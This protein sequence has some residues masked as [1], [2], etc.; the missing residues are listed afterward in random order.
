MTLRC[1]SAVAAFIFT[2]RILLYGGNMVWVESTWNETFPL[3]RVFTPTSY[4]FPDPYNLVRPHNILSNPPNLFGSKN[5]SRETLELGNMITH[6]VQQRPLP[7]KKG[8]GGIFLSLS[9]L[10]TPKHEKKTFRLWSPSTFWLGHWNLLEVP[11]EMVLGAN[12]H[13]RSKERNRL[14]PLGAKKTQPILWK[15]K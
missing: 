9:P 6:V 11:V 10:N 2:N 4:N 7:P 15:F 12:H 14:H 3:S 13:L 8:C 1:M 5:W